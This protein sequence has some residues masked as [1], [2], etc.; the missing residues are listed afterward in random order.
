MSFILYANP[1]DFPE[2]YDV[3]F[4]GGVKSPGI[5]EVSTPG[6]KY[7][8]DKKKG[9]GTKKRT[10]THRGT[11]GM[12]VKLKFKLW[13]SEHF[14][15]WPAYQSLFEY[16]PSKKN[17]KAIDITHPALVFLGVHNFVTENIGP[18]VHEGRGLY[19]VTIEVTE[20]SPPPKT[21]VTTTPTDVRQGV[22]I[23][24]ERPDARSN[25]EKERDRLLALAGAP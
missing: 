4:V 14:D 21:N 19:S 24:V 17:T 18:I 16:D 15:A 3:V 22:G 12:D 8:W 7:L 5:V 11:D 20:F 1:I 10:V 23:D 2:L 6:F 13:T 9:P 25:S